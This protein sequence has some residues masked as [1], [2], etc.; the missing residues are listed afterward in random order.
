M[1]G[2][3][4]IALHIAVV[5]SFLIISTSPPKVRTGI[6]TKANCALI[7]NMEKA[8]FAISP[9]PISKVV[10]NHAAQQLKRQQ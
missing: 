9:L 3:A 4:S 8:K 2:P 10:L 5:I 7:L 6:T 1:V